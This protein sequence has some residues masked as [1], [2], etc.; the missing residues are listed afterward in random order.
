MRTTVADVLMRTLLDRGVTHCFINT[1]TDYPALVE[2]WAK[3]RSEGIKLPD[4]VICPH[5]VV[6][7]SAAHGLAAV[8]GRPQA[9]FVHVDV[10]TQNLGGGVHNASRGRIPLFLFAG[11]SP[12]TVIGE[13][14]GSRDHYIH[15][16]QDVPDQRGIVRQYV[17]WDY[18]IR[19]G[20]NVE[21]VVSRAIQIATSAPEGPVYLMAAREVLESAAEARTVPAHPFVPVSSAA[22][23]PDGI[24][25]LADALLKARFPV[26]VTSYLGRSQAAVEALR[27]F[28]DKWAVGVVESR[29]QY[30]NFPANHVH[31]LGYDTD[32]AK[33]LGRADLVL[34][35]DADVP[36][37]PALE[38][39]AKGTR[40][41]HIDVDPLKE[42]MPLWYFPI[43]AAFQADAGL[44]LIQLTDAMGTQSVPDA[45]NAR[46]TVLATLHQ[47]L[48]RHWGE[49]ARKTEEADGFLNPA[50]VLDR[51]ARHL[52]QDTVVVQEAV[53]Q[54]ETASRFIPRTLPG[55]WLASGGSSL[56]WGGGAAIGAKLGQPDRPVVL[57]SGDG[58]YLFGNPAAVHWTARRYHA[59]FITVIL[60]NRG[61]GAVKGAVVS[62]H[63]KGAAAR[64]GS[65]WAG[66]DPPGD[67]AG[68]AA[69][70]G[71]AW[72]STVARAEDLEPALEMAWARLAEGQTAVISVF[73]TPVEPAIN[74]V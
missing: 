13:L 54:A 33:A 29:P 41:F 8:T 15:F 24:R 3:A 57:I 28:S 63:P 73:V 18:E 42:R 58:S 61:W 27:K 62:G 47:D 1:G 23:P 45:V 44:S 32:I 21:A 70:A 10:G 36:W 65:F 43:E 52:S 34:I 50:W 59:P 67:W 9:A 30:M 49:L 4:L 11:A 46:R 40:V 66:F 48:R 12:W 74:E 6:A 31:H 71:G 55:T 20:F 19:T 35:L 38:G 37:I 72:A 51:V 69:A 25:T 14:P 22:L 68:V 16:L 7:I 26:V 39:V 56:G 2:A 17:K 60:N 64:T 5:E 53:T